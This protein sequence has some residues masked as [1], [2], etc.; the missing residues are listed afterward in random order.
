MSTLGITRQQAETIYKD[1]QKIPVPS[2]LKEAQ[3]A[4]ADCTEEERLCLMS[5]CAY[6]PASDMANYPVSFFKKAVKDTL[7]IRQTLSPENLCG[8]ELFLNYVL[9]IRFNNEDLTDHRMDFYR[10]LFPRVKELTPEKAVLEV[11]YWCY[12]KATYRSTD[13][14]TASPLT[15]IRNT[16]GRCGEES[17][18]CVAALRSVGI[19]ARQCYTPKWAHCDDNHA[20]V[21]VFVNGA[22]H[23]IGACEPEAQLDKG[24]FTESASRAMLVHA[25]AFTQIRG[26]EEITLQT[27]VITQVNIMKN[28]ADTKTLTVQVTDAAGAP[29][30]GALVQFEVLNFSQLAPIAQLVTDAQGHTDLSTGYGD[31][32]IHAAKDGVFGEGIARR[33]DTEIYVQLCRTT[34][35][36]TPPV[37]VKMIPPPAGTATAITPAAEQQQHNARMKQAENIRKEY[38]DSFVQGEAAEKFA[39]NFPGNEAQVA[40]FI[41]RSNGNFPEIAGFLKDT[42][43]LSDKLN[44]LATLSEKDF[45]DT[46]CGLLQSHL[47]YALP[48]Q[49]QLGQALFVNYVLA[50]RV[51]HE[52]L[53]DFRPFIAGYFSLQQQTGFRQDPADIWTYLC[54]HVQDCGNWEYETLSATPQGLLRICFGSEKSIK[55]AFVAICRTLGIPARLH[56]VDQ[57]PEYWRNDSWNRPARQ[58]DTV[59]Q[60][61]TLTLKKSRGEAFVYGKNFSVDQYNRGVYKPMNLEETGFGETH[62]SYTLE[63][64]EYRVTVSNRLL[65]GSVDICFYHVRILP[66]A[67]TVQEIALPR[68][69][70]AEKKIYALEEIPVFLETGEIQNVLTLLPKA[71]PGGIAWLET[72]R[73][74]TEHLLNEILEQQEAFAQKNRQLILLVKNQA[75]KA[76]PLL[77]KAVA[78]T[79]LQVFVWAEEACAAAEIRQRVECA[80]QEF[81]LVIGVTDQKSGCF[82]VAGYHV[83]IGQLLLNHFKT[84]GEMLS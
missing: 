1:F 67:Q 32:W 14:R 34:Q 18:L 64:G 68:S 63:Q 84:E 31:L 58:E 22:W 20:W 69:V 13:F 70:Q 55:I 12:E 66:D 47:V 48:Y 57:A 37:S 25:R 73:E 79:G 60:T 11:N 50:P 52:T 53:S 39:R 10:E 16:Y 62:V 30:S 46:T 23:F 54:K 74:P 38:Q 83:G 19:P 17:V 59:F 36:G 35:A 44:L 78:C 71:Q 29:V 51:A 33:K 49:A 43:Q 2:V 45:S 15:V 27:P 21:E 26:G 65:D 24:W 72:G 76:Y 4:L 61:G 7:F 40:G 80:S 82:S 77:E 75:E 5:I 56:P 3:Q 28:Y 6:L 42:A 8:G 81:P 41:S 9:P